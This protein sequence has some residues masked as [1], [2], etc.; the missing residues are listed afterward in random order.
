ML[1]HPK[2]VEPLLKIGDGAHDKY[3]TDIK[4]VQ[5]RKIRFYISYFFLLGKQMTGRLYIPLSNDEYTVYPYFY[6]LIVVA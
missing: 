5:I 3:Q 4:Y 6:W 2:V 1:V